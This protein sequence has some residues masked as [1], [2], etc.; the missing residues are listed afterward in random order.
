MSARS[1]TRCAALLTLGATVAACGHGSLDLA[2]P[3]PAAVHEH[4]APH[5][6]TLLE[7]G[8][9]AAHVELVLDAE[10]GV[11]TAFTL[12]GEAENA[13]RIGQREIVVRIRA[14][15]RSAG[16][17]STIMDGFDLH[18]MAVS[19]ALTGETETESSQ[20]AASSDALKGVSGF[21]GTLS[22]LTIRGAT[23]AAVDFRY[24][25]GNKHE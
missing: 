20:F 3:A 19:N 1:K 6:G 4:H 14:L 24:P 22:A 8:E 7:L 2:S 10:D 13:V 17:P 12:D 25:E 16:A 11:L 15:A 5:G 9:E 18:L 21:R 23:F